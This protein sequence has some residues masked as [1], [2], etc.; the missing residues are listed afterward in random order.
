MFEPGKYYYTEAGRLQVPYVC[1]FKDSFRMQYNINIKD[2]MF[3]FGG[4]AEGVKVHLVREATLLEKCWLHRC[5][6]LEEFVPLIEVIE[7]YQI[8]PVYLQDYQ[9]MINEKAYKG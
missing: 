4:D 1:L 2:E 9:K 6:T 3:H 7:Y 5:K 8:E